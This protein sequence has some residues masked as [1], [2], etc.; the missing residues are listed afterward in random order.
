METNFLYSVKVPTIFLIQKC[1]DHIE[2][3]EVI[4]HFDITATFRS[5]KLT[6]IARSQKVTK[7]YV[8]GR[9]QSWENVATSEYC[10]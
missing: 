1:S 8:N 4:N 6:N 7:K 10:M 9:Q 2:M 3:N 5:D